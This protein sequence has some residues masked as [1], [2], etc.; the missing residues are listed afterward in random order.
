MPKSIADDLGKAATSDGAVATSRLNHYTMAS[1]GAAHVPATT[2]TASKTAANAP[3]SAATATQK[4]EWQYVDPQVISIEAS[5]L[6]ET[7]PTCR[8]Y[9]A[10]PFRRR[11]CRRGFA[12]ATS[13]R[14]YASYSRVTLIT[15]H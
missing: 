1:T 13:K 11:R 4:D 7:T 6:I 5:V 8:A 14:T 10:V 2:T 12:M 9:A 3:A 15:L